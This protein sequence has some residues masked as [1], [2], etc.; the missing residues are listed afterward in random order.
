MNRNGISEGLAQIPSGVFV[1]AADDSGKRSAMLASFVQ[2]SG[3]DPPSVTV[4]IN[5]KRLL[6]GAIEKSKRFTISTMS[7]DSKASLKH[8]WK[9]VPETLDPFEG[10]DTETHKTGI[11]ILKDAT[12]FLECEL[13]HTFDV[14]D[15]VIC[16]GKVLNGGRVSEKAP[17]VRIRTDGFEY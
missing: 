7:S 5:S 6:L 13:Q 11:P 16:V 1:V 10:L 12:A 4:A 3:F 2:Q 9:G 15:H 14:G 8:F 17:M